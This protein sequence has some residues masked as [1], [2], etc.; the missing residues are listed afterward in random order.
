MTDS[1][2]DGRAGV[3]SDLRP[4]RRRAVSRCWRDDMQGVEPE[5]RLGREE[6]LWLWKGLTGRK[7]AKFHNWAE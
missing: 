5:G 7:S 4:G 6:S 2:G 3:T 1:S